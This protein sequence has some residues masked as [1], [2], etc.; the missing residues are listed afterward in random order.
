M[1]RK[2]TVTLTETFDWNGETY[3]RYRREDNGALT[4]V[5]IMAR[6]RVPVRFAGGPNAEA[7]RRLRAG[8]L[9]RHPHLVR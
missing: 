5:K 4:D 3:S 8:R 2:I 6:G 1:P 7:A 9:W